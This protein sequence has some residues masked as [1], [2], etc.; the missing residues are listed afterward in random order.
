M[1]ITKSGVEKIT[2]LAKLK[3]AEDEKE[4]LIGELSQI[5]AYAEKLNDLNLEVYRQIPIF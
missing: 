4:K 1:V 5:I 3:F 2:K